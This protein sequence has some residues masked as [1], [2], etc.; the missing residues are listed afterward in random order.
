MSI[1]LAMIN[2]AKRVLGAMGVDYSELLKS[3]VASVRFEYTIYFFLL[4][5][6]VGVTSA[7]FKDVKNDN[8]IRHKALIAGVLILIEGICAVLAVICLN[9]CIHPLPIAVKEVLKIVKGL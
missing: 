2:H 3:M 4:I 1:S 7:L 5:A 6:G 9:R 8:E